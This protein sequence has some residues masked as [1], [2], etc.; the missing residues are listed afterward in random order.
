MDAT[1]PT[2]VG[3]DPRVDRFRSHTVAAFDAF[4]FSAVYSAV[5][6]SDG[7]HTSD[8]SRG[9]VVCS[10][11]I[12]YLPLWLVFLIA[13]DFFIVYFICAVCDP[14]GRDNVAYDEVGVVDPR[15]LR[16]ICVNITLVRS[17]FREE[18][19]AFP[20]LSPLPVLTPCAGVLFGNG[21]V[22]H[23]RRRGR[24][25]DRLFEHVYL[26][27]HI[28]VT[29]IRFRRPSVSLPGFIIVNSIPNP[30]VP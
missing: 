18:T 11:H 27:G 22:P 6:L 8:R 9:R 13:P 14:D 21:I 16:R 15:V 24:C 25:F 2:R 3:F 4:R 26:F 17:A 7:R 1:R 28:R 12:N 29:A 23:V 10:K 20:L 5:P 30:P 19:R